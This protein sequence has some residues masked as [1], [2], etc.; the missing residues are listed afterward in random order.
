MKKILS[1]L[2]AV[3]VVSTFMS[4]NKKGGNSKTPIADSAS[5]SIG[6]LY[7][8][9]ISGQLQQDTTKKLDKDAFIRGM[10]LIL[11]ADTSNESYVNGMNFGMQA[12]QMFQGIKMQSGF[13][14]NKELFLAAFK[15]AFMSD[16]VMDQQSLQALQTA[17]M[18]LIEKAS[19]EAKMN[20]PRAVQNL[21]AG[22]AY[23]NSQ[24][25]NG[26]QKTA[27][28]VLY[29]FVK[30]G[31]GKKFTKSDVVMLKYKGTHIDGK[32]FDESKEARPMPVQGTVPGFSEVLQLMSPGAVVHVIIP[33]EQAYGAN[34]SGAI[35]PNETLV[36]D[37]ETV[38]VQK[39]QAGQPN[40]QPQQV[41]IK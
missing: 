13:A 3:L 38:G 40:G 25:H 12:M 21:K 27:S 39:A 18:P 35:G 29:K 14:M 36:F 7:G 22:Q 20:D 32:V 34:G 2:L 19:K 24:A 26:Y 23:L 10:E 31:N 9:G 30:Q 17:L 1:I 5:T 8:Y 11:N 4:C 6:N 15:K 37:I 28:G 41:Q 16:S 33:S